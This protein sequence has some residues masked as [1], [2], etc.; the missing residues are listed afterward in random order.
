MVLL[1]ESKLNWNWNLILLVGSKMN[2]NN[3]TPETCPT[4][5]S[6]RMFGDIGRAE[7]MLRAGPLQ[8]QHAGIAFCNPDC[9]CQKSRRYCSVG[10][11]GS[12]SSMASVDSSAET[13][14]RNMPFACLTLSDASASLLGTGV[15]ET[16]Q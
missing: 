16:D 1:V 3:L 15:E 7:D 8:A 11:H 2:W 10:L 9:M 4:K 12:P 5:E 6:S 14:T 13:D